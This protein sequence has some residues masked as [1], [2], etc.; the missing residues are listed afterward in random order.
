MTGDDE[1]ILSLA[2][3]VADGWCVFVR[4]AANGEAHF[5]P[6]GSLGMGGEP[7]ADMNAAHVHGPELVEHT[8]QQ[9]LAH[10]R[11]RAL[12]GVLIAPSPVAGKVELS[13]GDPSVTERPAGPLMAAEAPALT[14]PEAEFATSRVDD[15]DELQDACVALDDAYDAPPGQAARMLGLRILASAAVDLFSARRG[16]LTVAVV[17]TVRLGSFVGIYTVGTRKDTRRQG[18]ASAAL[19]AALQQHTRSGARVFG[20]ES[21]VLAESFYARMGFVPIDLPRTWLVEW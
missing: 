12:P 20:L 18:A 5:W 1:S 7:F 9:C 3:S 4:G 6:G 2:R 16:R 21:E 13:I 15:Q 17:A 8:T 10:L 14:C 11:R 19:T